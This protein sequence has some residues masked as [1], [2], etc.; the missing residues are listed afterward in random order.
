MIRKAIALLVLLTWLVTPA[1]A[2]LTVEEV[3]RELYC[4]C[5]C[6]M[7]LA[8]CEETMICEVAKNMKG[9][10]QTMIDEGK[11]KEQILEAMQRMYGAVVL[12]T[13]PKEGFTLTLW[14]YPVTGL[15]IGGAVIY[16]ISKRRTDVEWFHDPDE[17]LEISEE[18]FA[19]LGGLE[20]K[21]YGGLSK[22]V[23]SRYNKLFEEEY[24]RYKDRRKEGT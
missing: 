9:Q 20:N 6:N 11:N 24:R 4:T 22:E 23:A 21:G 10:I 1:A 5:G 18:E 7:I 17:V 16:L 15:V 2:A 8:E 12:A 19:A 3:A 14:I 13:P